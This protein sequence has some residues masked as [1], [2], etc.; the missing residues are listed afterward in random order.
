[1]KQVS[2]VIYLVIQTC[3]QGRASLSFSVTCLRHMARS[4]HKS[5][6]STTQENSVVGVVSNMR[7]LSYIGIIEASIIHNYCVKLTKVPG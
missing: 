7:S 6:M 3:C 4:L 5:H 2:S 1:M